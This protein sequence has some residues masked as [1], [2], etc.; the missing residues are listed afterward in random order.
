MARTRK[1]DQ[2][3]TE[4]AALTLETERVSGEKTTEE[5]AAAIEAAAEAGNAARLKIDEGGIITL[6]DPEQ[7]LFA[8]V[9]NPCVYCGPT[10]RG[11]ARQYT[12]YQ[13]GLPDT[14]KAFIRKHPAARGL[15]APTGNF[16]AVRRR[17]DTPG[18]A[19]AKLYKQVKETLSHE[20][21]F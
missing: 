16:A 14:L 6:E 11:V 12:T 5:E 13:G 19:E 1:A 18:T 15:I 4:G 8:G 2:E 20:S 9:P 3:Q 17:L 7:A 10:V 21:P